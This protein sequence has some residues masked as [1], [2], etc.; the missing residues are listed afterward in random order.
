MVISRQ[1][2]GGDSKGNQPFMW[3]GRFTSATLVDPGRAALLLP[4]LQICDCPTRLPSPVMPLENKA[5][6]LPVSIGLRPRH[7]EYFLT[8]RC[9]ASPQPPHLQLWEAFAPGRCVTRAPH[10][11]AQHLARPS[12]EHVSCHWRPYFSLP[13]TSTTALPSSRRAR[14]TESDTYR[15]KLLAGYSL[16]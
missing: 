1:A 3:R 12:V 14:G 2:G 9:R 8:A 7:Q 16:S 13:S 11:T 5:A 4:T 15:K 10:Y 6:E